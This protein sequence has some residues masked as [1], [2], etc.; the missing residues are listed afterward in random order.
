MSTIN[1]VKF[2]FY[3]G[4]V[5]KSEERARQLITLAYQNAR[6]QKLYPKA[7]LIRSEIYKTTSINGIH[8]VDPL[9]YHVTLCFKDEQQL[10]RGTHVASHGY[11]RDQDNLEFI[12]APHT[13][14]KPDN[15]KRQRG[16]MDVWPP[17]HD[18][19][20]AAETGYS[21]LVPE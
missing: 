20:S 2:Y 1:L 9:G 12:K 13:P 16:T 15:T 4:F 21:H 6:D 11:V 19:V 17:E 10:L 3:K 14:E 8:Q 7:I 18:L 5:P